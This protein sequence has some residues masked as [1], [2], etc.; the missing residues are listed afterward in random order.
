MI[1]DLQIDIGDIVAGKFRIEEVLGTGIMGVVVVATDIKRN[2]RVALKFMDAHANQETLKR[3]QKE[4]VSTA[5]LT[6]DHVAKVLEFGRLTDGSPFIALEWLEGVNLK[7]VTDGNGPLP[8]E[9]ACEY[10]MQAAL[11]V[12]AAHAKGIIHRDI[13]PSNLFLTSVGGRTLIKVLD[14]GVA[15]VPSAEWQ[16][17][18]G[19][20]LGAPTFSSPEQIKSTRSVTPQADIWSLGATLYKL[21]TG[22]LPFPEANPALLITA[23]LKAEPAPFDDTLSQSIPAPLQAIVLRCLEKDPADRP[24]SALTLAALLAPFSLVP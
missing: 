19:S 18:V 20:R 5:S 6:T 8:T 3:F 15:K 17:A 13:K 11:G 23:I 7:T 4:A 21:L 22:T 2:E 12:A 10:V 9:Y 24:Q 14:F 16:T 1:G